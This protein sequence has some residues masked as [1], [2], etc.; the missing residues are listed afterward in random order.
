LE[1]KLNLDRYASAHYST[2]SVYDEDN[3][4]PYFPDWPGDDDEDEKIK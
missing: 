4:D 1:N 2:S 3:P